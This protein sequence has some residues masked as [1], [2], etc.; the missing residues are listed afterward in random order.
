LHC[1]DISGRVL[2]IGASDDED[3][4]G[5]EY[6]DYFSSAS[7]FVTSEVCSS[8]GTDLVLDVQSMPEVP[9]ESYD[10]IFCSGVLEHV[11]DFKSSVSEMHRV[12]SPN[13]IL[14]LGLP[15]CQGIHHAPTDYWRFTSF[16]IQH[17]LKDGFEILNLESIEETQPGFPVAY[18]CKARKVSTAT[19]TI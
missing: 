4:Q 5:R 13:G 18:W 14:L 17:L 19:T 10:A 11:F 2:S 12:L 16:G 3:G 8:F 9:D 1:K 15:F 7:D 6:R